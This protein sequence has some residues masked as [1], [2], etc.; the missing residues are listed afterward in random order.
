L[1]AFLKPD[2]IKLPDG[3]SSQNG[4]QGS[5]MTRLFAFLLIFISTATYAMYPEPATA[6]F[7]DWLFFSQGTGKNQLMWLSE[8][9]GGMLDGPFQGPMAFITDKRGNLWVGDSLNAR[10]LAVDSTGRPG[11][12]YDLI[13]AAREAGLASDPLLIDLVPNIN[14]KLLV[15]DASNNAIL[16]IN[17]SGGKSRAF[18]PPPAG[19]RWSQI[20]RVHTDGE[21]RIYVEDVAL[22]Q[23][24]IISQDGKPLQTL[25]GQ[26]GLAVAESSR[27]ALISASASDITEWYILTSD[28]PGSELK[29]LARLNAE[30]P[31]VWCSLIGYD[32]LNHLTAVFDT[33][34]ARH[35]VTFDSEGTILKKH[36]TPLQD[37]GYDVN[38]PDWIDKSG[39]IYTLQVKHPTLSILRLD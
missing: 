12:E 1:T 27:I 39:N 23:T 7:S 24:I 30:N 36:T 16:E 22:R 8:A 29:K 10:I 9:N 15:A 20:N 38:H 18:L 31:I 26:I 5:Y 2:I 3:N 13:K 11:R 19:H 32:S 25:T 34:L 6:D 35:Y 28:K 21:G 33:Q 37:P 17:V 4:D 14:N